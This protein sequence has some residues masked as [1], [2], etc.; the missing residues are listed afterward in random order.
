MKLSIYWTIS[1]YFQQSFQQSWKLD[2]NNMNI[3]E[4]NYWKI[5]ILKS[6]NLSESE[7]LIFIAKKYPQ[8]LN[9]AKQLFPNITESIDYF[10]QKT[11]KSQKELS[12]I[13]TKLGRADK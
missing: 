11:N 1:H 4:M 10:T 7:F 8:F 2:R 6:K 9:S 13:E 3:I 12:D 5:R